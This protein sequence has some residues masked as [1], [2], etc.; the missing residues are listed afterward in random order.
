[1]KNKRREE[2]SLILNEMIATLLDELP[3]EAHGA[4][5]SV[6]D[7]TFECGKKHG[8]ELADN[9][10]HVTLELVKAEVNTPIQ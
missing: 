9:Q 3:I 6:F 5:K 7:F 1:M 10:I 2:Y 8:I 4:F